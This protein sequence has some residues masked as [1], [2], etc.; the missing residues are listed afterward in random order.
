MSTTNITEVLISYDIACQ[1]SRKLRARLE[2]LPNEIRKNILQLVL[3][4]GVDTI[5]PKFH[6]PA[7]KVECQ[8]QY[9]LNYRFGAGRL[10]GEA[11]KRVWG[12]INGAADSTKEMKECHRHDTLDD[13]ISDMNWRKTSRLG[14]YKLL[15]LRRSLYDRCWDMI[16]TQQ[17]H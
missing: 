17:Q 7:H 4:D 15:V 14:E 13:I 16:F 9:S 1:W 6:L 3:N 10:D 12:H 2:R 11:P 8:S 5:I